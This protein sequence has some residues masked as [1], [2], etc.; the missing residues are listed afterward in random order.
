MQY[1][2]QMFH[3]EIGRHRRR[4]G[5]QGTGK[6]QGW[7]IDG[8]R[9][10]IALGNRAGRNLTTG[11]D[12]IAIGNESLAGESATI[13]IGTAG[14]HTRSFIA[15]IRG[16]T[17]VNANAIPVLI[18]SVGQLGTVSSSRRFKEDIVDM[19]AATDRLLDLRTVLFRYKERNADGNGPIELS[20]KGTTSFT[21]VIRQ[22]SI[23]STSRN[24]E[25]PSRCRRG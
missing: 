20:S 10:F 25:Q 18:D 13:R 6:Y 19:G 9:V 5:V 11:S 3:G 16:V 4:H 14:T 15:G 7:D 8:D 24:F 2:G 12:N 17:T 22:A 21:D 1:I 23:R